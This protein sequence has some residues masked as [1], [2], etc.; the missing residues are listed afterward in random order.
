MIMKCDDTNRPGSFE[1][2][3]EERD[4]TP[5]DAAAQPSGTDIPAE[6]PAPELDLPETTETPTTPEE[7]IDEP[8][9]V[10]WEQ[11]L[12]LAAEF[13]NYKKRTTREFAELVKTANIRLLRALVE[14]VDSFERALE[15][16]GGGNDAGAY[17]K[18]VEMI[19]GQ[20]RELLARERVSEIEAVGKP[21]D[22][23]FHEAM[24]QQESAEYEAGM[25]CGVIQ[26]GYMLEDRVLRHARVIVSKGAPPEENENS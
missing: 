12:R 16:A 3:P 9:Q 5:G 14:V 24:L 6:E 26:K 15:N 23:I 4:V 11:Y 25:I 1:E 10:D 19:Y 18:G 21:F 17:R 2:N 7:A 20:L 13:D 8:R 22:P